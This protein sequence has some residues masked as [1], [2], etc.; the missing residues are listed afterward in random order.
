[1]FA[2]ENVEPDLKFSI[3]DKTIAVECKYRGRFNKNNAVIW[4]YPEQI[5]RYQTYRKENNVPVFV[6]IGVDGKPDNPD[7]F[8]IIPLYR[9]TKE[10]ATKKYITPFQINN[11]EDA[12]RILKK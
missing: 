10:F 3:G 9:L 4:S 8:Y 6:A 2:E 5:E 12:I 11:P 7:N 1:M